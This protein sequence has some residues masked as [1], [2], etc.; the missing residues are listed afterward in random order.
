MGRTKIRLLVLDGQGVVFNRPLPS[1]LHQLAIDT[2]QTPES[3]WQRWY[4]ELRVP[5]WTGK[6]TETD[7][8]KKLSQRSLIDGASLQANL[9]SA[10]D[11]GPAAAHLA[12]WSMHVPIWLL[13]NHRSDWLLQRLDRFQLV[14][15]FERI[16]VSDAI[17][18]AKPD[19]LAFTPILQS[20]ENPSTALF[21]DDHERNVQAAF[22]LGLSV[23]HA[24]EAK[25][26][27]DVID[28][29]LG[30]D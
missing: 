2:D 28:Q 29:A 30:C 23:V 1:M 7:L 12:R 3:V 16:L 10:Y 22:K 5:F 11:Y 26:W 21:V 19:P 6:I 14:H 27:V 8:W 18:A 25:P 9:E 15:F 20:I 13:S 24:N 17:G 4:R